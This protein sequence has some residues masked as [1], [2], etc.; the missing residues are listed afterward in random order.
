MPDA[1]RCFVNERAITLPP[2]GT[3]LDAVSTFD[4]ALAARVTRGEAYVTDARA[5]RIDLARP[6]PAGAI[7]R[8]VV[9]A[10]AA[11]DDPDA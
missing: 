2:G 4:A 7:L 10:R 1:L 11:A 9:T 5:I 8:V 3:V 6:L